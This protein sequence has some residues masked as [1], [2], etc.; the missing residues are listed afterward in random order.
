MQLLNKNT[1]YA[2]RALLHLAG[3]SEDYTSS[4]EI[5]EV[6]DIPLPYVR[7]ILQALVRAGYLES[8]EGARGGVKLVKE[9]SEISVSE[10][11][12]LLQGDIQIS[13]CMFRKKICSKR[14]TCV[15]KKRINEIEKK[16]ADEF[17]NITIKSLLE[18]I[19]ER[20]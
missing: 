12:R 1:D 20:I 4:S 13:A 18:D 17:N 8:K 7:R 16:L 19:G 14:S 15:L 6:Q 10:L 5:S 11:I 3:K 9:P 2:I